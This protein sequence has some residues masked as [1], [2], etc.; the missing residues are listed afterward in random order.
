MSTGCMRIAHV[1]RVSGPSQTILPCIVP[2]FKNV[3]NRHPRMRARMSSRKDQPFTAIIRAADMTDEDVMPLVT[4]IHA[5]EDGEWEDAAL[6]TCRKVVEER[7]NLPTDRTVDSPYSLVVIIW[8]SKPD[9]LRFILFSDHYMSDGFSGLIVFNDLLKNITSIISGSTNSSDIPEELPVRPSLFDQLIRPSY[10]NYLMD[11]IILAIAPYGLRADIASYKPV[12]PIRND[13]K[14]FAIPVPR[15]PSNAFFRNG[16]SANLPAALSRCR[17]EHVTLHGAVIACIVMGFAKASQPTLHFDKGIFKMKLDSDFNMRKRV[18]E[19]FSEDT[20]GFNVTMNSL[21]SIYKEG[22]AL[23]TKFWDFARKAKKLNDSGLFS[24]EGMAQIV[25]MHNRFTSTTTK[26]EIDVPKAIFTDLN[27]SNLGQYPYNTVHHLPGALGAIELEGFHFYNSVPHIASGGVFF[28]SSVKQ[29]D[30]AF[31]SK[32]DDEKG[33]MVFD[34][35][36][37]AIEA[38]SSVAPDETLTGVCHRIF[39][40]V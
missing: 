32:F 20:V 35:V 39:G 12:L 9:R 4:I 5:D 2:A 13:Q 29:M 1:F 23:D 14:D 26:S 6:E 33:A 17:Q 34:Y 25:Y 40:D 37:R 16:D 31:M 15:N 18:K 10:F 19:P 28:V 21:D 22:V 38:I 3:F 8:K 27:L 11:T 7:C 24:F 36:C 30:Y